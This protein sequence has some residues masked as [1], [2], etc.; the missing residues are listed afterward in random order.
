MACSDYL[1]S[2]S[3]LK[4]RFEFPFQCPGMNV[5]SRQKVEVM[6]TCPTHFPSTRDHRPTLSVVSYL[7]TVVS[8][9][10]SRVLE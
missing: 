9:L 4:T 1:G 7:R 3:I 5:A 2:S 6:Q 10:L 8:C